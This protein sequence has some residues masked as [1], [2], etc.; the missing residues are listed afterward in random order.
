M[1]TP[2]RMLTAGDCALLHNSETSCWIE[3]EYST[4]FMFSPGSGMPC[5]MVDW[6][7]RVSTG[8]FTSATSALLSRLQAGDGIEPHPSS[9][10]GEWIIHLDGR[11]ITLKSKD[12]KESRITLTLD[13]FIYIC[14]KGSMNVDRQYESY[15]DIAQGKRLLDLAISKIIS[16]E[17]KTRVGSL[18]VRI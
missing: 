11:I 15:T 2:W 18:Q 4:W 14:P 3:L 16:E 13:G 7:L 5:R 12:M 6:D 1:S 17:F 9:F 10:S 8:L